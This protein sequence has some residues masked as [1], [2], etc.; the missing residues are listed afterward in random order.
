MNELM[1]T[2]QFAWSE[3]VL[4]YLFAGLTLVSALGVVWSKSIVRMAVWLFGAFAGVAMLFFLLD[5]HFLAV[6]QLIVYVGGVLVLIIFG[7]MLTSPSPWLKWDI[8]PLDYAMGTLVAMVMTA[9][10]V[11]MLS[12]V[13]WLEKTGSEAVIPVSSFGHAL[14]T[15][16]WVPFEVVS[17]LLLV[18][19]IGAAYLARRSRN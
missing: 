12:G 2:T 11:Y 9:A 5:A 17:V 6:V 10:M 15:D 3:D 18:V 19:M 1:M 8:K 7:I 4:F 14:L 13:R 16:Y